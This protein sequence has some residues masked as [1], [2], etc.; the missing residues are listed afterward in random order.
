M[1]RNQNN[2]QAGQAPKLGLEATTFVDANNINIRIRTSRGIFPGPQMVLIHRDH[3]EVARVITDTAGF[4]NY[5]DSYT[6]ID[7]KQVFLFE[8]FLAAGTEKASLTVEIPEKEVVITK[9]DDPQKVILIR[10]NDGNGNFRVFIRLLKMQGY[11]LETDVDVIFDGNR[12]AVRTDNRGLYCFCVPR[13]IQPGENFPLQVI[14]NGIE[15][16]ARLK[17]ARRNPRLHGPRRFS[18]AWFFRT[19]NGRAFI[20]MCL[21][22]VFWTWAAIIG[23]GKPLI[24]AYLFRGD[25]GLSRLE[26]TYNKV[27]EQAYEADAKT[28]VIQPTEVPGGWHHV[29]WKIAVILTLI[30]LIYGPLSLREEIA[31]EIS[32]AVENMMDRD[33]VKAG[34]P[35]FEKLVAWTGTYAVARNK[36]A[37]ASSVVSDSSAT[38]KSATPD[39]H[40]K[41]AWGHFPLYLLSD[42]VAE[43][44]PAIFRAI[45]RR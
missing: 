3:Q 23:I 2:G 10:T 15:D 35:W 29:I 34:D 16:H 9:K 33:Y 44:V 38:K 36:Q 30:L 22:L 45:F 14:V 13:S 39:A 6:Q 43:F 37:T 32:L 41:E 28:L 24:H 18:P 20:L 26:M 8:V 7:K 4:Y 5:A 40:K 27:M 12:Y 42:I 21:A 31:E 11:G 19:N 25:N 17:I 1:T